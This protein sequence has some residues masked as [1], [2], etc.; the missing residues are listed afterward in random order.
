MSQQEREQKAWF[1]TMAELALDSLPGSGLARAAFEQIRVR[2]RRDLE[3]ELDALKAERE[4]DQQTISRLSDV[5]ERQAEQ[6]EA[7]IDKNKL[8]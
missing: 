4:R 7:A 3:I 6:L 5:L 1:R 2:I 8:S